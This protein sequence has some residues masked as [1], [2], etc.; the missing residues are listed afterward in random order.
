MWHGVA[1]KPG[2]TPR[3]PA[4]PPVPG[5]TE[6]GFIAHDPPAVPYLRSGTLISPDG[7]AVG[8][9]DGSWT[10]FTELADGRLVLVQQK[11]LTVVGRQRRS[12]GLDGAI[13]SRPDG[14]A[15]AWTGTDG[16]VRRL[17]TGSA[18]P[19]VVPGGRQLSPAC[20]G[21]R[22][23]G[24]PEPG[25]QTCDRDGGLLS[26]DGTYFASV[27][28]VSVTL[29]PR[30]DITAGVSTAFL[31]VVLDAVWEDDG[32]LLVVV[33]AADEARLMRVGVIG[34]TEDLIAPVRGANDRTRPVLVL[35][36]T[37]MQP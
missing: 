10:D 32:H 36:A 27:G 6:T 2:A 14:A 19:V 5:S 8:I 11:S 20:R 31:G 15:V 23:D 34:D 12:Y 24:R 22:I 16:R 28:S 29:A 33:V 21:I 35:P 3:H 9:P 13:T 7:R 1:D 4:T 26:P 25:W 30:A 17:D 37:A 18:E